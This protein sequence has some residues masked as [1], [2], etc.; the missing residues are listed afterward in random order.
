MVNAPSTMFES[1]P[2]FTSHAQ[3]SGSGTDSPLEASREP[4]KG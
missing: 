4:E 2:P 1:A 3:A